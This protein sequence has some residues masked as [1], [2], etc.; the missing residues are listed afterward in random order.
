MPQD[1]PIR[2]VL[3]ALRWCSA[4][5]LEPGGVLRTPPDSA[6]NT[7]GVILSGI[8]VRLSLFEASPKSRFGSLLRGYFLIWAGSFS[9]PFQGLLHCPDSETPLGL[10]GL[11]P[12]WPNDLASPDHLARPFRQRRLRPVGAP[13]LG[14]QT[15][16][17]GGFAPSGW[18]RGFSLW[19]I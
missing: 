11:L 16:T 9:R 3:R 10:A 8:L 7:L 14:N 4:L 13:P 18:P 6:P 1:W 2:P 12:K 19:A 5:Y 17:F 15:A